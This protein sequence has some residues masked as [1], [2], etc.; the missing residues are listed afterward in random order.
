MITTSLEKS[1]DKDEFEIDVKRLHLPYILKT[2]CPKCG[3]EL[4]RNYSNM[5]Y[6][7]YPNI[8]H[9]QES[10]WCD[11]CDNEWKLCLNLK[12]SLELVGDTK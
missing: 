5:E 11:E 2:K 1:N 3:K 8:G 6:L 7:I 9:N 12:V 10:F 4:S